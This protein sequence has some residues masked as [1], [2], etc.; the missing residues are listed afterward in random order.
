MTRKPKAK[1]KMPSVSMAAAI[2]L[3]VL[4]GAIVLAVA[5]A[6]NADPDAALAKADK[7]FDQKNYKEAADA[8]QALLAAAPKHK[9][10][11]H[12]NKRIIICRLR[13]SLF[14]PALEA[15]EEYIGRC[16][17]TP[18]EARAQRLAGNLYMLVPHWGTRAGGTFHRARQLAQRADRVHLRSGR[19]VQPVRH[20]REQLAVLV[21]LLGPAG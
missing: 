9:K 12:A 3:A 10:W 17:G 8:Y 4:V 2:V 5:A 1:P 16:K 20:L 14:D 11:H 21:S 13:L 19:D 15:A 7:L 18:Y 6:R